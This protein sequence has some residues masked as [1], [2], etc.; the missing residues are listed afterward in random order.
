MTRHIDVFEPTDF[1][2]IRVNNRIFRSATDEG[3]ADD[4]G[5]PTEQLMRLSED[6]AE[7][8]VGCIFT[9]YMGVEDGAVPMKNMALI[10]SDDKIPLLSEM[11]S[12]VHALGCPIVCQIAHAGS[13][14]LSGKV[15]VSKISETE[16]VRIRD[17]FI[18]SA[19]RAHKAGF[20]GVQLHCAH[21]YLLSEFL[22]PAT[23]RRK[24]G[25]GGDEV[26][27]FRIVAGIIAGISSILPGYPIMVKMNG[28][29]D[30]KN[31]VTPEMA[32]R[33]AKMMEDAGINGIEVSCSLG[34]GLGPMHGDVPMEM[35]FDDL[36]GVKGT[37]RIFKPVMRILIK[38][39]VKINGPRRMYN[40]Q[41][42][43]MIRAA[44]KIPVVAVGGI[45]DMNEI[46]EVVNQMNIDFVAMSRPLIIE[47]N[48]IS[49]YKE[50]KAKRSRCTECNRCVIGVHQRPLKC[51]LRE[52]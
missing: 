5:F 16:I 27:R 12:R 37:P 1:A 20:D 38:R 40:V 39:T 15:K 49:K 3:M 8:G 47:P 11:A 46:E 26:K 29:E 6:L 44:V 10:D 45:H 25:W 30:V 24:D 14:S 42:A 7:G 22:S 19:I 35:M 2:G 21:G 48:L 52:K 33:T 4:N 50:G 36:P 28:S 9:T 51:Y 18:D 17:M 32:V 41:A 23:N 31:G 13:R 43:E 34:E